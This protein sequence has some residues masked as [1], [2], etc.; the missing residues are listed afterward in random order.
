MSRRVV[1]VPTVALL[2]WLIAILAAGSAPAAAQETDPEPAQIAFSN[3]VS[4]N[5]PADEFSDTNNGK[6]SLREALQAVNT[7]AQNPHGNQGCGQI[8]DFSEYFI[9]LQ[10]TTY[11]LTIAQEL[12]N[13]GRKITMTG[14]TGTV[15]DGGSQAGR[16][17]GILIVAAG[18]LIIKKVKFQ[19]GYRPFGGAMWIKPGGSAIVRG[20]DLEFYRNRADNGSG[21][22][23]GG[24]VAA[25]GGIFH[26][27]R[28][29]FIENRARMA[30]GA[31][32]GGSA[33][34]TLE[35][36]DFFRNQ[37]EVAGGALAFYGGS[38]SLHSIVRK[39]KLHENFVNQVT[40]PPGWPNSYD[41]GDDQS[42]GG[43]I[44]VNGAG[45]VELDRADIFK[46]YTQ[47]SK[48]GGAI[49]NQGTV[50]MID[51]AL[52]KNEARED[53]KV[54]NTLGGA[55]L[56]DSEVVA[57]RVSIHDN[58]AT[59]GGAIM[60]RTSGDLW[61]LN[62]TVAANQAKADGGIANGY[63]FPV[64]NQQVVGEGGTANIWL[65][66][67]ARAKDDGGSAN[68]SNI[69]NGTIY[70][71]N[72][73]IDS[74][75]TGTITS[76]GGN[77]FVEF[78]Q[79]VSADNINDKTLLDV[80][81][82]KIAD[83][84]IE[85]LSDNGGANTPMAQFLSIKAGDSSPAIDLGQDD[86]CTDPI[87]NPD[88]QIT[89]DQVGEGRPLGNHCDAG[90][91]ETGS[92]EPVWFIEPE[93]NGLTFDAVFPEVKP[94][95]DATLT[96]GNK[97]GGLITWSAEI[98]DHAGG[99]FTWESEAR[100]GGLGKDQFAKLEFRCTPINLGWTYGW[101]RIVTNAQGH[102]EILLRLACKMVQPNSAAAMP[103]NQPGSFAMAD[104]QPGTASNAQ[105]NVN[106]QGANPLATTVDWQE[107][108]GNTLAFSG[109]VAAAGGA[110]QEAQFTVNPGVTLTLELT[111][112]PDAP[113]YYFNTLQIAT[114][115]PVDPLL[116]YDVACV[117]A[118]PRRPE[119]LAL[120][121][122]VPDAASKVS[123]IALS[124]D[125]KQLLTGHFDDEDLV[126]YA[127][128]DVTAG[129]LSF[130]GATGQPNMGAITAIRYSADGKFVYHT[131]REGAGVVVYAVEGN[132][133]LTH[134]QT[135]TKDTTYICGVIPNDPFPIFVQ[136]PLNA[137]LGA[138]DLAISPD[139][140]QV[141]VTG[142][143]DDTLTVLARDPE[144]GKLGRSQAITR[145][146]EGMEILEA[147]F[148]V[149]AA[150]DGNSVYVT[151]RDSDTVV[152]FTRLGNG[153]L[154]YLVHY[155]DEAG[156]VTALDG[157]VALA[158]SPDGKYLYAGSVGDDAIQIFAR[159]PSD[160]YITPA[161]AATGINNPFA[162]AMSRD[163]EGVR[164][165]AAQFS[166]DRITV[167][168]RDRVS[169][170]LTLLP[171]QAELTM[172]S[173]V[174]LA[175]SADNRHVYA[176]LYDGQGV[177]RLQSLQLE[178]LIYSMSP[179]SRP[180]GSEDFTLSV[181]GAQFYAGSEVRWNN[182]PLAT[183]RVSATRLTAQVP[184]ALLAGAGTAEVTV[185]TGPLGGGDST[186]LPFVVLAENQGPVPS[187]E[188][189]D[190][191]SIPY[192]SGPVTVTVYGAGFTQQSRVHLNGAPVSTIYVHGGLLLAELSEAEVASAGSLAISVVN[193]TEAAAAGADAV[194]AAT[195]SAPVLF[196][197][198]APGAAGPASITALE[199]ASLEKDSASQWITLRG[200]N[201]S[202][203]E[204]AL[205]VGYWNGR[206]RDTSVLDGTVLMMRLTNADLDH[207]GQAQVTVY[208]PGVGQSAARVFTVLAVGDK[209]VPQVSS[210]SPGAGSETTVVV[211]GQNFVDGATVR[212]NGNVCPTVY[213]NPFVVEAT[214]TEAQVEAGGFVRVENP[215][216]GGGLSN[217][218]Y[219][220]ARPEEPPPPPLPVELYLPQME[221]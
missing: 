68:V 195:S 154:R 211:S 10:A 80:V 132:G 158:I 42:G 180:E 104:T 102:E 220:A 100:S 114:N 13:I 219:L 84:G 159:D 138:R 179:A 199:P 36:N 47:R 148:D 128:S 221:R 2:G 121:E 150:P 94:Y 115:D 89:K 153:R 20:T 91:M 32:S 19:N 72:S 4:V 116:S 133:S 140:G 166:V 93:G 163:P 62:S 112:N 186:S 152:A 1:L 204:D 139:G 206:P 165:L 117:G 88:F 48:G 99:V 110:A 96:L 188:S 191:A 173:P 177:Q 129:T 60:N 76:W 22:G 63:S 141:Y 86:H 53:G 15:F 92:T 113:G 52:A 58:K 109:G 90:A 216:P 46:N 106:N 5:T 108:G 44:Y 40:V 35:E 3:M 169:G 111:C 73:I 26:C 189:I 155:Q 137:M 95:G 14:K 97:G 193:G 103:D 24:A 61:V 214:L 49:Y 66:T 21:N 130:Q 25:D 101:L 203:A 147:P 209:P 75:C 11:L 175:S 79:R 43:A 210:V 151:G 135:I 34:I 7:G 6:C 81:V 55:I 33:Q 69:G 45:F 145:T 149:L 217:G 57:R 146:V 131:T 27:L 167:L 38:E 170:T 192:G 157:P 176:V 9:D 12:P 23:D 172:D 134:V 98:T 50:W 67:I 218:V 161:G 77:V 187:V 83:V 82:E 181:I 143:I 78:C 124:P 71:A 162:L 207:A 200:Y 70:M 105:I 125:G 212:L 8:G 202:G 164:V 85:G 37:A 174:A 18:E 205:T 17:N 31:L 54:P 194:E 198:V 87:I 16:S 39:T 119:A 56:N 30:G 197:T 107:M 41:Y 168:A 74:V 160:G 118:P 123:A 208:T 64:N 196:S 182:S 185:H 29:K 120:Q 183:T 190:P 144:S 28:C 201:F 178:P 59:R 171:G 65:S 215:G 127:I 51:T 126:A 122:F 136:C 156:G 142:D 213:I 184:A